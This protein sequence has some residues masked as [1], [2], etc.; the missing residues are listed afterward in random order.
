MLP[1]SINFFLKFHTVQSR[2]V[3]IL[4]L[5]SNRGNQAHFGKRSQAVPAA[6]T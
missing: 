2:N 3:V 4:L 6:I 1:G 5:A